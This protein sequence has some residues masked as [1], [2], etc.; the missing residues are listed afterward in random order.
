MKEAMPA[1][2][3][4]DREKSAPR[5]CE[6]FR[7]AIERRRVKLYEQAWDECVRRERACGAVRRAAEKKLREAAARAHEREAAALAQLRDEVQEVE[8]RIEYVTAFGEQLCV[9]GSSAALGSWD[10]ARSHSMSWTE[11]GVWLATVKLCSDEL[12]EYKYVVRHGAGFLWEGGDNHSFRVP[13][14]RMQVSDR[15]NAG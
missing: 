12:V 6:Q 7:E 4:G 3:P 8:F 1:L 2:D 11:G 9:V 5:Q 13:K 14:W 10:V 15:W